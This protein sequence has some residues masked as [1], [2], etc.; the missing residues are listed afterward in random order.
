MCGWPSEWTR[1]R[2]GRVVTSVLA[3]GDDDDV[4]VDVLVIHGGDDGVAE[5]V[6]VRSS[7]VAAVVTSW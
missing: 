2:S 4:V 3:D 7:V 5:F 1:P 6:Q